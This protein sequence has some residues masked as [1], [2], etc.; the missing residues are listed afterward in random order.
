MK[1]KS[2]LKKWCISILTLFIC[3]HII[4]FVVT[5]CLGIPHAAFWLD[6]VKYT[7]GKDIRTYIAAINDVYPRWIL[8]D[9]RPEDQLELKEKYLTGGMDTILDHN[10]YAYEGDDGYFFTYKDDVFYSYGSTGFFVIYA[11]PFQIKLIRNENLSG[12]KRK[13]V[14]RGLSRYTEN[15]FKLLTSTDQLTMKEKE[16][17]ERLQIKAKERIEALKNANEYP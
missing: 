14:D 10:V 11:E 5:F 12:E 13:I 9:T 2:K 3:Y 17:Y 16:E 4:S 7:F 6:N 8:C 1:N 15:E